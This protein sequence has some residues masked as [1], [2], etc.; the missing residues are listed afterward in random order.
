MQTSRSGIRLRLKSPAFWR[1]LGISL[2]LS[3]A[4]TA[5]TQAYR[6]WL[7]WKKT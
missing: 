1:S 2:G 4:L 6:L 5:L 7:A 3:L